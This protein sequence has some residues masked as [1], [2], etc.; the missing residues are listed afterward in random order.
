METENPFKQIFI[1]DP[2][3]A[4]RV[5]D[6]LDPKL[7]PFLSIFSKTLADDIM[8]GLAQEISFGR[9][10][11]MGFVDLIESVG[12]KQIH[13]YHQLIRKYGAKGPTLGKIMAEHLV[14]VLK[15]RHPDLLVKYL[16]TID[17]MSQKGT[18]TLYGPLK[19]L[20]VLCQ[21]KDVLSV[22][23]W[24]DLLM[25]T[26]IKDLTYSQYRHFSYTL[27]KVVAT[28]SEN[29]RV[30][31]TEQLLRIIRADFHLADNF[32][33]GL[34]NGL[35][36]LSKAA[37]DDFVT[38]G[39]DK[40]KKSKN[41]CA[42]F[43]SLESKQGLDTF[44]TLQVTVPLSLVRQP[45]NQ[46]IKARTGLP[47]SIKPLSSL[48]ESLFNAI[49][50]QPTVC[51][52]GKFI[53]LPKEIS[54]FDNKR[55][56]LNFYK[57]LARLE[58]SLFEF[59]TFDFDLEKVTERIDHLSLPNTL[60]SPYTS[61]LERF[62]A[63]FPV[64]HLASDLFTVFEHGRIR[65]L[66]SRYYPGLIRRALPILQD[67]AM[68][69]SKDTDP[70]N[71]LSLL[72]QRIA[73][74]LSVEKML[75]I[76]E[77]ECQWLIRIF[78]LHNQKIT[79]D[80]SVE[81]SAELVL[82]V[83]PDIENRLTKILRSD[84]IGS[85]DCFLQT[86]FQ[87]RIRPE[88]YFSALRN[89]DLIAQALK[90]KLENKGI[91][92]YRSTI[93]KRL[94]ESNGSLSL[95]DIKEIVFSQPARNRSSE[96]D[97]QD[98]ATVDARLNFSDLDALKLF[99]STGIT[100]APEEDISRSVFWYKEWD[101]RLGDYLHNHNRV[102]DRIIPGREGDFYGNA[103]NRHKNLVKQIR[104]AFELLKPE[105]L[106]ILRQWVEGDEFDYRALL[107]FAM[108]KKAGIMPS[109]KL[110]IKRIK[111]QRDVA[112]LLLMDLSRSTSTM[113][114]DSDNTVLDVEK[115][116]VVL[117]CEAL[118]VV[119]DSYGIAGF[120]GTGRLGVDYFRIKDFD[121]DLNDTVR[122]RI[123]AIA[124]QRSTR[125]GAAI[126]H[127]TAQLE[128][129]PSKVRLLI[130]I[131][132]GFPNDVDYKKD[133]AIADTRQAILEGRSKNIYAHALTVNITQDSK[134]DELYGNVHHN[135]IADIRELP[136]KLP[137]IY[138]SLTRY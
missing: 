7:S 21:T 22:S 28:F 99:E 110:Y 104:Y 130:I 102:F 95:M 20:A 78:D 32:I 63:Y 13:A 71:L 48:P 133:Y 79:T 91:R 54:R 42:K 82:M 107:D 138:S 77:D 106:S 89:L 16:K 51:S 109:D 132:D 46:Y 53:Y 108:D 35:S 30:F 75:G 57:C 119:G 58:A 41:R 84:D 81:T 33:D 14:Y 36:L 23:V 11:A 27:P 76:D 129:I 115:Q 1:A 61:D 3:L 73:L 94:Y 116:A 18:Y 136:D 80:P 103:L 126:R 38:R 121:E 64:N 101:S 60:D 37:L 24:L 8:W 87:R 122:Q 127:A 69:M 83:Y 56:N 39:L 128:K 52:D 12:E 100:A 134:L 125:M 9:A 66:L 85:G 114:G 43:L 47:V 6:K 92:V 45:I 59:G 112:V 118:E 111:Q 44:T 40:L 117:F 68:Q 2:E 105:G 55:Q 72:Y 19:A 98:P 4:D 88:L 17:V 34:A 65:M 113:V 86:P 25:E 67:E 93:R 5:K 49:D 29:K 135:V 74:N 124:P 26:F 120:S 62:L 31:Q 137:R 97:N 50:D 15:L 90:E 131:G 123:N 70:V 96:D 10:I